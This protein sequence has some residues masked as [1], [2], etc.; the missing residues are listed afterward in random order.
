MSSE[1]YLSENSGDTQ[2]DLDAPV[3]QI[4]SVSKCYQIYVNPQDRLK[5][6]ILPRVQKLSG[7]AP[8][9]YFREFWALQDVSLTVRKGETVGII[10]QNGSGK[11]TL[12][13]ILCG[14]LHPS[15]GEV[16]IVGRVGALLELGSGFNPEFTGRENVYLNGAVLGLTEQQIDE[17][18]DRIVEFA[19]IGDF[20]DQPVKQYSSGM[21]VRLAFAVIAH[22]DADILVIDEALSVGDVFFGQKCMRFLRD[23]MTRGTVVFVSHDTSAVLNLCDR[24]IWL[25][26]GKVVMEGASKE[27]MALYLEELYYDDS[28][29]SAESAFA[30]PLVAPTQEMQPRDMRQDLI[31]A[32]QLRNDIE[33]F[34]FSDKS[35]QFGTG[36]ASVLRAGFF[37]QDS[38]PLS[39]VVGGELVRIS[40]WCEAR[41]EMLQPIVGFEVY[42]RLGQTIF[43][44]NTHLSTLLQPV[45]VKAGE[46]ILADFDFRMPVMRQGDYT[47]SIAIAEGSQTDHVQHHWLHEA[48]A[49]H[50]HP[51]TICLGLIAVPMHGISLN[52]LRRSQESDVGAVQASSERVDR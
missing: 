18:F 40:I 16:S 11:S 27:V 15:G 43:A 49:F 34:D 22:A 26:K 19:D 32:S 28:I 29:Q 35:R 3:I 5:Q 25:Q 41:S 30:T 12:L 8:K 6:S 4:Q 7:R 23:F 45:R 17:R 36:M 52:V 13:Q 9:K 51:K 50:V 47:I 20:L 2:S 33:I 1:I 24:V 44:D 10:G 48:L 37:D 42:D 46:T 38:R 39:W 31:N 21:Y 14:T